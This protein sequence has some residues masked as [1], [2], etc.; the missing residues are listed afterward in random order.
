MYAFSVAD[1]S[2]KQWT[3]RRG[4]D[5]SPE[6]SPDGTKIAY[7]GHDWKFQSYDVTNLYIMDTDGSNSKLLTAKF[8]R[9]VHSSR[10]SADSKTIFFLADDHGGSQLY[11]ARLDGTIK[12]LTKGTQ[13]LRTGHGTKQPVT[14]A[15]DGRLAT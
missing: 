4:Q 7:L 9:D 12:Q 3:N 14:A 5:M 10:W 13:R 6:V 2:V 8:D 15:A 1:G 11:A